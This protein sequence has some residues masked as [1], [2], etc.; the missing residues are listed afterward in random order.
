M[1]RD[2]FVVTDWEYSAIEVDPS[3]SSDREEFEE[4]RKSSPLSIDMIS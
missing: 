2:C 1:G 3:C 4:P